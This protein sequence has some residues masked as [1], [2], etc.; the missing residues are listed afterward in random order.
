L[1]KYDI[2]VDDYLEIVYYKLRR[3]EEE[4]EIFPGENKE[5]LDFNPDEEY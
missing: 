4:E 2:Q 1:K 5:Y 3:G